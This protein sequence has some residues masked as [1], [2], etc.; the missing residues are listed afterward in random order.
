MSEFVHIVALDAPSPPDYGGAIDMYY[1]VEA[2]SNLGK[3][4]IL[5]YFNYKE[6]RTVTGL[7]K[8]CHAIFSYKRNIGWRSVS[9]NTPY[10]VQ[11]RINRD[12]I[13]RLNNDE[14]PII[15][16]GIH[17]TGLLKYLQN[18][19][20]KIVIRLHNDEARYY[21]N[22]A[23]SE[24]HFFKKAYYS[25]ESSLLEK[26]QRQL[27]KAIAI[28]GLSTSD[29]TY[30]EDKGFTNLHFVPTFLPWQQISSDI[31]KGTYCL[32]HG[33]L[34]VSENEQAA[35]WLMEQVFSKC[36]FP[37]VIA[38]KDISNKLKE[39]AKNFANVECINKPSNE[40][41]QEL[42]RLAHINVLPSFNSTGVKLKILN[43]LFNGR[44]CISNAAGIIGSAVENCISLTNNE[45]EVVD[46]INHLFSIS[47]SPDHI[48]TREKALSLYNNET[49]AL[50]LSAL[51]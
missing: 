18:K 1:K 44:F 34:T 16:E 11:S 48:V 35:V 38:G 30:F 32:Y 7:E 25:F 41:L 24:N 4:V 31:G 8:H 37:L 26:Y 13:K 15:L 22:L 23:R 33:N 49:N 39:K 50:K 29:L 10:I 40:R 46:M 36:A 14:Y 12:L 21:S 20:R 19:D 3:K 27:P 43:A 28:A 2:L 51:I 17:C 5:H 9:L 6:S 42:I 45:K 47:F